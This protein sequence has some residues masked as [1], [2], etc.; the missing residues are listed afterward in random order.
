MNNL[1]YL[2]ELSGITPKQL[3]KLLNVSVHTYKA[4]EQGRLSISKTYLQM[5]G[6]IYSVEL[7][8]FLVPIEE[9]GEST[10]EKMYR[11]SCLTEEQRYAVLCNNLTDGN[12]SNVTYRDVRKVKEK[13]DD[14]SSFEVFL[15]NYRK[16]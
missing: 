11:L 9:I 15:Q 13:L 8:V 2:R 5:L 10:I 6:K 7:N 1:K 4:L 12:C 3:A 16:D 14:S